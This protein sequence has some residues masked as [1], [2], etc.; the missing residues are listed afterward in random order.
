MTT[1]TDRRLSGDH[2]QCPGCGELFNSTYAFDSHRT[3]AHS[4]NRRRCLTVD[5]MRGQG[6]E[7]NQGGWW[8][9][10]PRLPG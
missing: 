5:E 2:N 8:T 1:R 9:T 10:A 4:G 7:K 3:G 6:M